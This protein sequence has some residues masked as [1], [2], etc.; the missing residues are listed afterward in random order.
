MA[1]ELSLSGV[2]A[3]PTVEQLLV[4]L[5]E[6]ER[7]IVELSGKVVELS[8]RVTQLEAR[9][10]KTSQN[11]SKPPSSDAFVKPPP[12]SLRRRSGRGPGKQ[13]GGQGFRLEPRAVPDEVV[14]H[15]PAACRS[16]GGDLAGAPVVAQERRQVFDPPPV[17][18]MAVEHRAQRRACGCGTVTTAAFPPEG[19]CWSRST[20]TSRLPRPAGR[21]RC[22]RGGWPATAAATGTWSPKAQR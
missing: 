4:L 7:V 5:A 11:S 10:G 6:R 21:P 15:V 1:D 9:L 3:D 18:L 14:V 16:C 17:R 8:A 20:A 22:P 19:T 2:P 13:P 12:R